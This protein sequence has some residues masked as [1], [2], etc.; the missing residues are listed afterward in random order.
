MGLRF[1]ISSKLSGD[2]DVAG[3]RTTI[4]SQRFQTPPQ[5]RIYM[6]S[7]WAT[8]DGDALSPN[9]YL[10]SEELSEASLTTPVS[11]QSGG[12]RWQS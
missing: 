12:R 11:Q 10:S 1:C 8:D 3:P 2:T 7:T 9:S 5:A 4:E 6:P